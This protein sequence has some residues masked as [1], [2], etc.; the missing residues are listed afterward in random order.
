M[1]SEIRA[2]RWSSGY[3]SNQPVIV[4]DTSRGYVRAFVE[5]MDARD[6]PRGHG[7]DDNRK[8]NDTAKSFTGESSDSA[9]GM[10]DKE[11]SHRPR[12]AE[13]LDAK[14]RE[15]WIEMD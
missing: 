7:G 11:L 5:E 12:P 1:A 15:V 9:L 3:R 4:A 14:T 8:E 2:N 6:V 13:K 10:E